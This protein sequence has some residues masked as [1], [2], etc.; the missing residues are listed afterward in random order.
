MS[1][2]NSPLKCAFNHWEEIMLIKVTTDKTV[3][4]TAIVKMM[5]EAAAG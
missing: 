4:E 3:S 5:Q 1:F 2:H